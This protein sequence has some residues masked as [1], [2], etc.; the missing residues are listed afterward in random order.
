M[1]KKIISVVLIVAPITLLAQAP[2]KLPLDGKKFVA[3]ITEDGKKK[4]LDPDDL[5]FNSG[6]FKSAL[7]ADVGWDFNKAAKYEITKDSTTVD[8]VKIYSWV[9][10]LVNE[11]EEKCTFFTCQNFVIDSLIDLKI[12][13][14]IILM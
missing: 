14:G 12:F 10:D 3:E 6:K 7:F 1:F 5:T 4:P 11:N 8:G 9:D 13:A 2:K